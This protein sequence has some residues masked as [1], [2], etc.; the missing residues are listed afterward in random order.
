MH[1]GNL[2]H[3]QHK[4]FIK[5]SWCES[6]NEFSQRDYI[7]ILFMCQE[8][9]CDTFFMRSEVDFLSLKAKNYVAA[10]AEKQ[11]WKRI[12]KYKPLCC[13][14]PTKKRATKS[15]RPL[16]VFYSPRQE[17]KVYQSICALW[18]EMSWKGT[19]I[20]LSSWTKIPSNLL[21]NYQFVICHY[22]VIWYCK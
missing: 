9:Q 4:L 19:V 2:C 5:P 8:V 7:S 17:N 20:F 1:R 15:S 14:N 16:W 12:E 21:T 3:R 18:K 10:A 6:L 11:W 22:K 13:Y